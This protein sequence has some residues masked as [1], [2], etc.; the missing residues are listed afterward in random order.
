MTDEK[1]A[2]FEMIEKRADHDFSPEFMRSDGCDV[3]GFE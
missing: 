1:M 3:R 2:L